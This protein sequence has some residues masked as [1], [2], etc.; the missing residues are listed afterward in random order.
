VNIKSDVGYFDKVRSAEIVN[1]R[2]G[3]DVDPRLRE[4]MQK[5]VLHL[6]AFVKEVNP[7]SDEWME[8]IKFLTQTGQ[9]CSEWR[10]EFIL[11]SDVLGV[12]MLVDAINHQRPQGATENTVLGP[13]H[14]ANAPRYANGANICL[15][16][17][18]EPLVVRGKVVDIDG[19]PVEGA[20]LDVWATNDDGFYDVQQHGIQPDFN[21]RGIFTT[22]ADGSYWFRS[23]KPRFYP[24]PADGPVGE[25]LAALGRHPNRAAHL[26]FIIEKAGFERVVTH[27][28]TPDCNYLAEDAVFGVK[29]SLIATFQH[30]EDPEAATQI[31][32]PSP[33]WEV[34]WNFTLVSDKG[35]RR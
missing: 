15:D 35:N 20:S 34:E 6:H 26:H 22:E 17:K 28:F 7:T 14:V 11:L 33:F 9:M 1:A 4:M 25:L 5:L 21:L 30:V 29:S 8:G 12:S 3:P 32:L 2:M 13:F 27:I 10:Q 24:I 16:G 31:G 23:S 19:K 18:G